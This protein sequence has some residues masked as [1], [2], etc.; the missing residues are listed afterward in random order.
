MKK[1]KCLFI[2]LL[3][4][5]LYQSCMPDIELSGSIY[6]TV[7]DKATGEPIKSVWVELLPSGLKTTTGSDGAFEFIEIDP[8]VYSLSVR[9]AGY[10]DYASDSIIVQHGQTVKADIQI[11]R[12]PPA[13][14][15]V[16]D[17]RKKIDTLDFGGAE[18][19]LARS[20]NIFNDGDASLEWQIT[21]TAEW[22]KSISKTEGKLAAGATQSIVVVIDRS[23]LKNGVNKTTLH[24]TSNNGSKQL[25]ILAMGEVVTMLN[26]LP[27]TDVNSASA[28]L[29]GEILIEG[30]PKYTEL[31][32]V[33]SDSSMP[34]ISQCIKKNTVPST[35]EK[36][37]SAIITELNINTTYYARAYAIQ[38]GKEIYSANEVTFIPKNSPG[39]VKTLDVKCYNAS[40]VRFMGEVL[41][42]GTPTYSECG[43]VVGTNSNPKI[44]NDRKVIAPY[45]GK[46]GEFE[47][48]ITDPSLDI[49]SY[50]RA[51]I[52]N[53]EDISYGEALEFTIQS[54]APKVQKPTITE[55]S[56][57]KRQVGFKSCILDFGIPS[58]TEFGFV[59]STT[60]QPTVDKS[61]KLVVDN[62]YDSKYYSI[63]EQNLTIDTEY[64]IRAF[65]TS[66]AG[67][68][69]SE[70]TK[71]DLYPIL[72]KLE[73]F[74]VTDFS[75]TSAKLKG[76]ICTI[77][78][79]AYT[80]C[81]F[82]YGTMSSPSL[83]NG[84]IALSSGY[85]GTGTLEEIAIDLEFN[86]QYY[87]RIYARTPNTVIYGA[88]QS[89]VIPKAAAPIFSVGENNK[90]VFSSGNLQHNPSTGK[91]RFAANQTD[92]IGE[93]NKN[94]STTYNG[95]IDLFGWSGSGA[96]SIK[97]G[98]GSSTTISDYYGTFVDYGNNIIEEFLPN[99]WRTL[100]IEEWEYIL[101][102]RHNAVFL[103]GI[104]QVDG[105]NGLILLPDN[106][107]CPSN[108][109]FLH[110]LNTSPAMSA[111]AHY[112]CFSKDEWQALE[113]SG[114]IFLPAAGTREG[115]EVTN[116]QTTGAYM[117]SVGNVS[118]IYIPGTAGTTSRPATVTP[119]KLIYTY[120]TQC[121]RFG[122]DAL[123]VVSYTKP[124]GC[125]VRLV[126]DI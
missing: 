25:T 4:G 47:M 92:Y 117:S 75:G 9:K 33:Y 79:P 18:D 112:Q 52:M 19:D 30:I 20:F 102:D 63:T 6:G 43:F 24:I 32:F 123:D 62:T 94:I 40:L 60:S 35:N 74:E 5:G 125:C 55:I 57:E 53:G 68:F 13:L 109:T 120:I 103:R 65:I 16:D 14:M 34:T 17:N 82:V 126:Q 10:I 54:T 72:P 115:C 70:E 88:E 39:K 29:N 1:I 73:T 59:Y 41:E 80:D 83:E 71:F 106:W 38:E 61:T 37:F 116:I 42:I 69:Y 44:E 124:T 122:A 89:F 67:T 36:K 99:T 105:V 96:N 49:I 31:G 64:Y 66:R 15:V 76:K 22:I 58:C 95:W 84:A 48:S 90:V 98:V 56:R 51:Y 118:Y 97:Y 50:V 8:S 26:S 110:G 3:F 81:G 23:K 45:T 7:E 113:Y 111:F 87:V 100:S 11:E 91:W 121:I 108:L 27:A 101:N 2:L 86:Q 77:G 46:I 85:I 93:N 21:K 107:V 12:L 104:A 119:S 78:D 114:A 28:T